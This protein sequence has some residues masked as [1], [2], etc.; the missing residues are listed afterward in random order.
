[1]EL[2]GPL[3]LAGDLLVGALPGS[4]H[5]L[6]WCAVCS[7][8]SATWDGTVY[9]LQ[10][11]LAAPGLPPITAPVYMEVDSNTAGGM[12]SD[13]TRALRATVM[14]AP[15]C[16]SQLSNYRA[17]TLNIQQ[18]MATG[19][20]VSMALYAT[21]TAGDFGDAGTAPTEVPSPSMAQLIDTSVSQ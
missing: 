15:S 8:L 21:G 10:Q 13:T 14:Y 20:A 2:P 18:S 5:W 7:K 12:G 19:Q 11:T 16:D 3:L 6:L 4:V 17:A 9:G 1:A